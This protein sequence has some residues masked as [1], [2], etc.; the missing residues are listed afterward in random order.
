MKSRHLYA[1]IAVLLISAFLNLSI[2]QDEENPDEPGPMPDTPVDGGISILLAAG[3]AYGSYRLGRK[4][5]ED[6]S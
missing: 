5:A 3:A 6:K 2:A 1:T 4:N